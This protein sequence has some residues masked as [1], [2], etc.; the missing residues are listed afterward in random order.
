MTPFISSL[1]AGSP[2]RVMLSVG[3]QSYPSR[4][5]K[6]WLFRFPRQGSLGTF[7]RVGSVV[8]KTPTD[9]EVHVQV[10]AS[11]EFQSCT[12]TCISHC[13]LKGYLEVSPTRDGM[14]VDK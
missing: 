4:V 9:C 3:S 10:V 12:C 6:T 14:N 7:E 8:L 11:K 1:K 5:C 2:N 13:F